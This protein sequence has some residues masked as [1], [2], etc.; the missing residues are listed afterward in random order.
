MAF[1][2]APVFYSFELVSECNNNCKGCSNFSLSKNA[3][4]RSS[5]WEQIL[6]SIAPNIEILKLTGGEP[7]LHPEFADIVNFLS[8]KNIQ[9]TLFTNA[10]WSNPQAIIN[11]LKSTSTCGGLLVSLHGSDAATHEAFTNAP[12]S[13][14]ETCENI[15]RAV[16]EGLRIHT[17]TVL[18]RYNYNQ[19]Q[20]I[21][22]LS[23]T[24]GAR[25]A[26]FNRYIGPYILDISPDQW[27]IKIA[28][29]KI[30]EL[31][32]S[33]NGFQQSP[34]KYGNC[35]PQCFA[36][37]SSSGCWA[38]IASCTID[39]GGNL[40]PCNHSPTI[41]GNILEEPIEVIWDNEIMNRWREML[42]GQCNDCSQLEICHGGCRAQAELLN[43]QQ[44]P[45]I[46]RPILKDHI[47]CPI[48]LDLCEASYP[49]LE[50]QIRSQSFGY[51]LLQ[52]HSILAVT[53][54]AKFILDN[55]NGQRTLRQIQHD[56]GQEA[57]DLV[58]TL[59][60]CGM[61]S[62]SNRPTL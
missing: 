19:I 36:R 42:P 31:I 37:N 46:H 23:Q 3:S 16:R 55:L 9:F 59:Y 25:R 40:R 4:H 57:L 22:N 32:R 62:L 39:P 6:N 14:E 41:A 35:F 21:F 34:V 27:Q 7:T 12:G 24:L 60:L 48:E 54:Q 18:T 2:S 29:K 8:K 13:F 17:S 53:P 43:A 61:V 49:L 28:M 44:D 52:G 30:E 38:G 45:L 47:Q 15:K 51:V 11:L 1:L 33:V 26:V 50:C 20:A 58:G 56:F 5:N 10:R